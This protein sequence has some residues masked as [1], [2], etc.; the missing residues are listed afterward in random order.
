[1]GKI[2]L[3]FATNNANKVN[4]I[5]SIIGDNFNILSLSDVNC[6][7]E[8][9]ETQTTLK[10][11]AIQK[12]KYLSDNYNANCFADDTGLI[13]DE[14]NGE[15]GVY[16]ARYAGPQRNAEDNMNLLLSKL[17]GIQNRSA[18]F[19]TVIALIYNGTEHTFTGEVKGHIAAKK[20]GQEG[21]G[22]DPIFIPE[23]YNTS[24]SEMSLE[25]KNKISHRGIAT[26]KLIEFLR[27]LE[28]N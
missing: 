5:Q 15:P 12:A 22:Y 21:F 25:E 23:G 20:S 19:Q 3:V 28:S 2:N 10:G 6:S 13:V 14:L 1:M 7:E 8:L 11:N 9:P 27:N 16:S 18:K 4:E 17:D 26:R 24:F